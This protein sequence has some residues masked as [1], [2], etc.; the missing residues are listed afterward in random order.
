[1]ALQ[2]LCRPLDFSGTMF[3]RIRNTIFHVTPKTD[4]QDRRQQAVDLQDP[5][6]AKAMSGESHSLVFQRWFLY[7]PGKLSECLAHTTT[8]SF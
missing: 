5:N 4:A 6:Q 3:E 2:F 1:M 7:V 8:C